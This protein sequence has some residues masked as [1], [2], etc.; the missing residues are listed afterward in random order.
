MS[1]G[2]IRAPGRSQAGEGSGAVTSPNRES[3][4]MHIFG[5]GGTLHTSLARLNSKI[6]LKNQPGWLPRLPPAL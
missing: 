6:V 2:S 1:I 5:A 4:G 3:E